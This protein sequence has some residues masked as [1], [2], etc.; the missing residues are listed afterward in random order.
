MSNTS[1]SH[2]LNLCQ[3][4]FKTFVDIDQQKTSCVCGSQEILEKCCGVYL[5]AQ[6][7]LPNAVTLMRARYSAFYLGLPQFLAY[8]DQQDWDLSD[9]KKIRRHLLNNRWVYLRILT[10]SP[11]EQIEESWVE[12]EA[13]F[14]DRSTQQ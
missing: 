12:F 5:S 2:I 6:Q 9:V 13:Y 3:Q 11:P 14:Q 8:T 1:T 10:Y 7:R 4:E